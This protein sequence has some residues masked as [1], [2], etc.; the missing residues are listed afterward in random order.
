MN[1]VVGKI[2]FGHFVHMVEWMRKFVVGSLATKNV[3]DNY[4]NS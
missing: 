1:F 3:A 4:K 2:V